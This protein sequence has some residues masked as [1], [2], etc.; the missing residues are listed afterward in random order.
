MMDRY[1]RSGFN[2]TFFR[3]SVLSEVARF[4][5]HATSAFYKGFRMLIRV[6]SDG[7]TFLSLDFALL[8]SSKS[9]INGINEKIDKRTCGYKRHQ[10]AIQPAPQVVVSMLDCALLKELVAVAAPVESKKR[11][12]LRSI[13]TELACGIPVHVVFVRHGTNKKKWLGS[14]FKQK[15]KL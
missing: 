4:K 11:N 9:S 6:W 14:V 7:H 3:A 2:P 12:I 1:N 15:N 10:E 5:D 13:R 8:S